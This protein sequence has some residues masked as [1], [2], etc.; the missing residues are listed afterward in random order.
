MFERLAALFAGEDEASAGGA[1]KL[2]L[3]AAIL[4]VEAARMDG[5]FDETERAT[6]HR[7]LTWRFAI[8]DSEA[9]ELIAAADA[10]AEKAVELRPNDQGAFLVRRAHRADRDDVDGGLCGRP[11]RRLR[12][13]SH[14]PRRGPP[15]CL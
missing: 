4:L 14:A 12:G 13:Q 9:D 5:E 15:L 6:I 10:E 7:L 3:A 1:D 11:S 2:T 8:N